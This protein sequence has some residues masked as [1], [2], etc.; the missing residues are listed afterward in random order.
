MFQLLT[1]LKFHVPV[2]YDRVYTAAC[3][4]STSSLPH[5]TYHVDLLYVSYDSLTY[6]F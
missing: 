5:S 3:H 2:V 4:S 1:F 6:V